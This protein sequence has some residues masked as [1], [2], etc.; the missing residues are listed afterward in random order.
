MIMSKMIIAFCDLRKKYLSMRKD[1]DGAVATVLKRGRYILDREV[2]DFEKEFASYCGCPYGVGVGSGTEALH[3]ALLSCGIARADE[4]ITVANA[5]VPTVAA[6]MLA[7]AVP[8]FA[9]IDPASFTI[10][11]AKVEKRITRRT[12]AILPV[13]LYGQC[14]DMSPLI[15]IAKKHGLKVI[16]DACQAHGALYRGRPAGSVGD[17]AAFSFYP[18]K[19]LGCYGDGGM[20]I[21]GDRR[22][23]S[24]ARMIREYGQVERYHHIRKGLN[25]RL[26]EIQAAVLRVKLRRLNTDNQRRIK[27]AAIYNEKISNPLVIKPEKMDYGRHVYHLYVVKSR[28][29]DALKEYLKGKGI[30]TIM[31]YPI[32][33]YRQ[34]AYEEFKK[35]SPCPL[36]DKISDMVLSL[37]L[38][39][40]MPER[41]IYY[42][43][44]AINKFKR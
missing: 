40:E 34:K 22:I 25:S 13:H 17:A 1:I 35:K 30:Q 15:K 36:T 7:G 6:I 14:A 23:A 41:E 16:E 8:V 32:P 18:T 26:D 10:D 28:R 33:V 5:G 2:G 20:V 37:P 42:I 29:R 4:V 27:L 12:K 11:A 24:A 44:G 43:C 3:V 31:H 39:P 19:N 9:D 38:Y 21:T